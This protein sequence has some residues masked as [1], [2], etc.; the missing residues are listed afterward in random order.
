MNNIDKSIPQGTCIPPSV[1]EFAVEERK[2]LLEKI[3]LMF[4][5]IS[6]YERA[7][8]QTYPNGATGGAFVAW[9]AARKQLE[10]VL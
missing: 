10:G 1:A 7:L 8:Q 2:M 3:D 5:A 9:N 4:E 6:Y